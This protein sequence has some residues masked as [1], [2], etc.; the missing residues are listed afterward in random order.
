MQR[1]RG[2]L[3]GASGEFMGARGISL[4]QAFLSTNFNT[5]INS[6]CKI[7]F[8]VEYSWGIVTSSPSITRFLQLKLL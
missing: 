4:C 5:V 6:T 1:P 3:M 7:I 2:E 8:K